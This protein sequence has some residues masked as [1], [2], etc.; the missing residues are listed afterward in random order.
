[1]I[2]QASSHAC[3]RLPPARRRRSSP[4]LG[5]A[6][7][8]R[9]A[10]FV[11]LRSTRAPSAPARRKCSFSNPRLSEAATRGTAAEK[12]RADRLATNLLP[13]A[14]QGRASSGRLLGHAGRAEAPKC[15]WRGLAPEAASL[16]PARGSLATAF[17]F[18]TRGRKNRRHLSCCLF[19]ASPSPS[20]RR[21]KRNK[22][23]PHLFVA[24][25]SIDA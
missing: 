25:A 12:S 9:G 4:V 2:L 17:I 23:P 6:F 24:R 15:Q 18:A 8:A 7:P 19:P 3:P 5:A 11:P 13:L 10:A 14:F 20:P 1:M 16:G 22:S 21:A